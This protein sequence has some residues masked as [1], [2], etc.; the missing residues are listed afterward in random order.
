MD[1]L[2]LAVELLFTAVFV[3]AVA[4]CVRRPDPVRRAV[5][6]VF[7]AMAAIFLLSVVRALTG[8]APPELS[9][10]ALVLLLGQPFFTLRLGAQVEA[11]PRPATATAAAAWIGSSA[12][13]VALGPSAPPAA[14]VAA[15]TA[16]VAVELAAAGLFAAAARRRSGTAGARLWLAS[17]ATVL[18]ALALF[19]AG[20]A[21]GA[22]A[23]SGRILAGESARAAALVSALGY[24]AAFIPPGPLRRIWQ[25]QTAYRG[26]R[27]LLDAADAGPREVWARLLALARGATGSDAT[28]LVSPGLGGEPWI[29][30][31][32]GLPD[33]LVGGRLVGWASLDGSG[34][35]VELAEP[36]ADPL[37]D[38][39]RAAHL[40]FARAVP[41]GGHGALPALLLLSRGRSLFERDD[42]E[43][44][45]VLGSQASRLVALGETLAEQEQLA[46]RLG[47][48]VDALR[49]A[50]QAKS[51]FLAT[52][53]HELRTP[54]N[55]ILGFSDL[56]LREDPDPA[57]RIA[58]S[59]EWIEHI[60]RGGR[61]L[62][63]LVNDVL[64]L[65]RVEAGRLDLAVEAIDPHT[66]AA[67]AVAG[68]RPL[69]DRKGQTLEVALSRG[70]RVLAD[71][72]RLRQVLYNLLS[73]A[74][75]FTP[76][77][78]AIRVEGGPDGG[79]FRLAVVDTGVGISAE[80]QEH[81]FEEFRQVGDAPQ[82]SEGSGLGLTLTRRLL[83][84]QRG[85]IE[86]ASELGRGSRF[87]AVLPL[88][89]ESPAEDAAP[90]ALPGPAQG[91]ARQSVLVV[92]DDPS[93][94]RLLRAYL[95]PEGYEVRVAP[96]GETGL[97]A[98][99]AQPPTAI[100][101]DVLLPDI[102]GWEVL[103]RLKS[104]PI[105]RSVP[106]VIVTV[107]D[108][109][110]V[111]LALGAV[112]YLVKPID[113]GALLATLA[114]FAGPP[115]AGRRDRRVLAVDDEPATLDFLEGV[116]RPAGF[117]VVRATD[118][119]DA[120][121]VAVQDPPDLVICDLVMPGLDGFGVVTALKADPATRSVPVVILTGHELTAA[122][123][124]RLNGQVLGV[125][126]KGPD[127]RRG[128]HDW[129]SR[130]PAAG[131]PDG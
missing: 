14:A 47:S 68:L 60:H 22:P 56:L 120:L 51:D 107:V 38:E 125:V 61:Q 37:V 87:T 103:R 41:I 75:K 66:L 110:D 69:A 63:E 11:V 53:S 34:R 10:V 42:L 20:A 8:A 123:K 62:V 108:E 32:N 23:G 35:E 124:E 25:A 27:E 5:V 55:A 36:A 78:G 67:E 119:F 83:E 115:P 43:L 59:L 81:V 16:F 85:R 86:L 116:L 92:E 33:A 57:G 121:G 126:S 24:A 64:D 105:A 12:L 111:G 96:D 98:A 52:M 74:I 82:R 31:V 99:A 113:R 84:A 18:F 28:T 70:A 77:G 65:A 101:L 76:E 94:V 15:V 1:A 19:G 49:S 54:L 117:D 17:C 129:L 93:A 50:S 71:R 114:R 48:T 7:A 79:E 58:A 104:D 40:R 13:L 128:L 6:L 118:G 106:V 29:A 91:P 3:A 9:A 2:T 26:L 73:N 95:E 130:I 30:A 46:A 45:G 89:P 100:L 39:A 127:A 4:A 122:D 102:D 21:A 72:G 109:R 80:D 97:A 88:A 112:D 90:A 44:L 131:G